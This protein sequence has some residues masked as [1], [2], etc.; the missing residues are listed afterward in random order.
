MAA[1]PGLITHLV[2]ADL[3]R[4][5]KN[6][7]SSSEGLWSDLFGLLFPEKSRANKIVEA[8]KV[9]IEIKAPKDHYVPVPREEAS[10]KQLNEWKKDCFKILLLGEEQA[11]TIQFISY[12]DNVCQG[13]RLQDFQNPSVP[14]TKVVN[15]E[16]Q[17]QTGI[18]DLY[19]L[20]TISCPTISSTP[21]SPA[22]TIQILSIPG[23]RNVHGPQF[24]SEWQ[25]SITDILEREL[26]TIDAVIVLADSMKETLST[27]TR[28]ALD[29]ICSMFPKAA[30]PNIGFLVMSCDWPIINFDSASLPK[31]YQEVPLWAL[32]DPQGRWNEYIEAERKELFTGSL[33][34]RTTYANQL[35][36]KALGPLN[37]F[38]GWLDALPVQPVSSLKD[39][40]N[41]LSTI[42]EL[43]STIMPLIVL[44]RIKRDEITQ[45][46]A[47][48]RE[49]ESVRY[50]F[51]FLD[52]D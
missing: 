42:Q 7:I 17:D 8:P 4:L 40:N 10:P 2:V 38:F 24:D 1:L 36:E 30:F 52:C 41:R 45:L 11:G 25:N 50:F 46:Q 12:L 20:Y 19:T 21:D 33:R 37:D 47:Q 29:N 26:T 28:H 16:R 3:I 18:A 9:E 14:E 51:L 27:T 39:L 35:Y 13:R 15:V 31:E 44:S 48:I 43:V 34:H 23:L 6:Q 49:S 32:R 22:K 5:A